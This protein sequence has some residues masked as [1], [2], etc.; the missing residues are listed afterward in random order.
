MSK[1]MSTS[2]DMPRERLLSLGSGALSDAEL[3][4][5]HLGTGRQGQH[6]LTLARELL[7]H[8]GGVGGLSRAGVDELARIPGVGQ[9]KA[10][11]VVAAFALADRVGA[12]EWPVVRSSADLAALA[13]PRIGRARTEQVLLIVLDGANRLRQVLPL[14]T[15]GATSSDLPVREALALTLRHDGV[16]MGL[17]HNHPG[18]DPTPSVKDVEV[19]RRVRAAAQQVGVRFLDHVVVTADDWRSVSAAG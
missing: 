4:A 18:G 16:A 9:A 3:V 17:A 6:V 8:F 12:P 5:I 10:A 15:G 19:T 13:Q 2:Q 14:A 11:R 1:I 7:G